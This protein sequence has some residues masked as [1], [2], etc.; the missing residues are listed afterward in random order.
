[1]SV[2]T[3]LVLARGRS[4]V[5][6][7]R[8]GGAAPRPGARRR[9]R[10]RQAEVELVARRLQQQPSSGS[11]RRRRAVVRGRG[12][13]DGVVAGAAVRV[14]ALRCARRGG[15]GVLGRRGGGGGGDQAADAAVEPVHV[16][17]RE[18]GG[19]GGERAQ[20]LAAEHGVRGGLAQVPVARP[21]EPDGAAHRVDGP[22]AGLVEQGPEEGC[23]VLFV[24]TVPAWLR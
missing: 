11:S 16:A 22:P 4:R 15:G 17:V 8:A 7:G 5:L 23:I 21:H 10:W 6:V 18:R 13:R 1:M 19:D 12:R 2:I 20:R 14:P 3:G 24:R 9:Q